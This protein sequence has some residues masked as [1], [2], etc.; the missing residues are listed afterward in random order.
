LILDSPNTMIKNLWKRWNKKT[1]YDE[2]IQSWEKLEGLLGLTHS[3]AKDHSASSIESSDLPRL[4]DIAQLLS[5]ITAILIKEDQEI[6]DIRE[7]GDCLEYALNNGFC[8]KLCAAAETNQPL[9]IMEVVLIVITNLLGGIKNQH[10]LPHMSVHPPIYRLLNSIQ[11]SLE[12]KVEYQAKDA[13]IDFV[14]ILSDKILSNST[15]V[16]LFYSTAFTLDK[17]T[18]KLYLIFSLLH[19]YF[20]NE[21]F[22]QNE[23][24][25]RGI[26]NCLLLDDKKIN[27]YIFEETDFVDNLLKA[28]VFYFRCLPG[29]LDNCNKQDEVVP[30]IFRQERTLPRSDSNMA[31][32]SGTIDTEP[33]GEETSPA[34]KEFERFAKFLSKVCNLI[35]YGR[36]I[37]RIRE[38]FSE[39]FMDGFLFPK[40]FSSDKKVAAIHTFYLQL[41]IKNIKFKPL[42]ED[43]VAKLFSDS[44]TDQSQGRI[45]SPKL[46]LFKRITAPEQDLSLV[47]LGL[48]EVL[49]RRKSKKMIDMVLLE[50]LPLE[51]VDEVDLTKKISLPSICI[52]SFNS[53]LN[54]SFNREINFDA[55]KKNYEADI[56]NGILKWQSVF[57]TPPEK[58]EEGQGGELNADE[59][60]E[61]D[62]LDISDE[63]SKFKTPEK[64]SFRGATGTSITRFTA[65]Q[66]LATLSI[67]ELKERVSRQNPALT[68]D[69]FLVSPMGKPV[70]DICIFEHHFL[71]YLMKKLDDLPTNDIETNLFVASILRSIV[72]LPCAYLGIKDKALHALQYLIFN[73]NFITKDQSLSLMN[74]FKQIS[75]ELDSQ[76]FHVG[77]FANV[78]EFAKMCQG[79]DFRHEIVA[80]RRPT[81]SKRAMEMQDDMVLPDKYKK[82]KHLFDAS[83]VFHELVKEVRII[84]ETKRELESIENAYNEYHL[85]NDLHMI[86]EYY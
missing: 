45:K 44:F 17:N 71:Y 18:P 29:Y 25:R 14:G 74:A 6:S 7:V 49:F 15:L 51:V 40:L 36:S 30:A 42:I 46:T 70:N 23:N 84:L 50:D 48:F 21:A 57:E 33:D 38:T 2:L 72:M 85:T 52:A 55:H 22:D 62:L 56:N 53:V 26:I 77:N 10:F 28:L 34:V 65:E 9:G 5:T 75:Q 76:R 16:D 67:K 3:F 41:L 4:T 43:I 13:I 79:L 58:N 64:S 61:T 12:N 32:S 54:L 35:P 63:A 20:V 80:P 24:L 82:Y 11:T 8:E 69:S 19:Y 86:N 78:L 37:E 31:C 1:T 81:K 68:F 60:L 39:I 73:P 66:S 47:T 83:L 27:Y 59:D